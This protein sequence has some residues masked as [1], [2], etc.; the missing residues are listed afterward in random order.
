[1]SK[2]RV[3]V[4]AG[5]LLLIACSGDRLHIVATVPD[6]YGPAVMAMRLSVLDVPEVLPFDCDD[7]AFGRLASVGARRNTVQQVSVARGGNADLIDVAR[8]GPKVLWM[9]GVTAENI[10][11]V[12]GCAAVS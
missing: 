2:P 9:E 6:A 1:M 8:D 12:Q 11:I 4:A 3:A 10:T 5:L 7:L